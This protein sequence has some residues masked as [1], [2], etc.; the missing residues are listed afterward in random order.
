MVKQERAART[1]HTLVQ[2]AA[3]LFDRQ[4]YAATSL[5]QITKLTGGISAGALNFHFSSKAELAQ[6]V[7][8]AGHEAVACALDALDAD[9]AP[10]DQLVELTLTLARLLDTD[11]TVRASVRLERELPVEVSSS[12]LWLTRVDVLLQQAYEAGQLQPKA[13]PETVA[14]LVTHLVAGTEARVRRLRTDRPGTDTDA[15]T[16]TDAVALLDDIWHLVLPGVAATPG[17]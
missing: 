4:G 13:T 7:S 10:L 5:A 3:A 8:A 11:D 6:A 15:V 9:G 1:R 12:R 2:N 17:R 14:G 16:S